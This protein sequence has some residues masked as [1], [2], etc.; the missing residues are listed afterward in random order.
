MILAIVILFVGIRLFY[1]MAEICFEKDWPKNTCGGLGLSLALLAI[2]LM[3][4]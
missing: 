4:Y 2:C 1:S 3:V